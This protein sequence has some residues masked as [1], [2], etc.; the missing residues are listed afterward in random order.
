[1]TAIGDVK[2]RRS[3]V[4]LASHGVHKVLMLIIM[5]NL[6]LARMEHIIFAEIL[7]RRKEL[8]GVIPMTPTRPGSCANLWAIPSLTAATKMKHS[9]VTELS[10]IEDAKVRA[11]QVSPVFLGIQTVYRLIRMNT[12][13]SMERSEA[14]TTAAIPMAK[15]R[16]SGALL[17]IH[18][19]QRRRCASPLVQ[20][21]VSIVMRA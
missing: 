3:R 17:V 2:I 5:P 14:I 4:K 7:I 18:K 6:T 15:K 19:I 1:M 20:L 9:R 16:Q 8:Y 10:S 21:H 11:S 13:I 12:V